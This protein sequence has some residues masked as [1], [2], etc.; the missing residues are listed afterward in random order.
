MV[1]V[2]LPLARQRLKEVRFFF[3]PEYSYVVPASR[4]AVEW[5]LH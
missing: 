1:E 4:P 2:A 5:K 3:F